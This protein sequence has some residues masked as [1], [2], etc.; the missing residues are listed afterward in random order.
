MLSY[1]SLNAD[2]TGAFSKSHMRC[3]FFEFTFAFKV[4][5]FL[6]FAFFFKILFSCLRNDDVFLSCAGS[7]LK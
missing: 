4:R 6:F 5:V 1:Y 3:S 2:L 7:H